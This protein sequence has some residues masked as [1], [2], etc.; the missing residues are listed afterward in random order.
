MPHRDDAPVG[1]RLEGDRILVPTGSRTRKVRN[2][3]ADPRVRV[4]VMAPVAV[5]G[6]DDGWVA[7]D[8]RADVVRGEEAQRL[9]R[10]A[11][12]RYL[13]HEGRRGYERTFLPLLDVTIAVTPDRWQSWK[14]ISMLQTMLEHGY[15]EDDVARWYVQ[16]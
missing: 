6:E 8:G 5:T 15:T 11:M 4:L 16:Q 12:E 14:S 13:T 1:F 10:M 3:E 7:A 9:N 2:A